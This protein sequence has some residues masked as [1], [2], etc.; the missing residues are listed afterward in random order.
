MTHLGTADGLPADGINGIVETPEGI[1]AATVGGLAFID[2]DMRISVPEDD[3]VKGANVESMASDDEGM[4]YCVTND[5]MLF[6]VKNGTVKSLYF[7]EDTARLF[8]TGIQNVLPDTEQ[9]CAYII[10]SGSSNIYYCRLGE[11]IEIVR[12][13]S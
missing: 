4:V 3:R 5:G 8:G 7:A 12:T 1:Y 13:I 9:G 6:T 2:R 11:S 10:C